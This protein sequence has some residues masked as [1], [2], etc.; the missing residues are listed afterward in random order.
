MNNLPSYCG[1]VDARIR[2]SDK[3]LHVCTYVNFSFKTDY[4]KWVDRKGIEHPPP[5]L[6][7][8]FV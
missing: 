5:G 6:N 4:F 8:L 7:K 1:L 3:D 2:A